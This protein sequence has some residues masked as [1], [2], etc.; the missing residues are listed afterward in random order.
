MATFNES[1]FELCRNGSADE[2]L[3]AIRAGADV[4]ARTPDGYM[5]LGIAAM[6][7][8]DIESVRVL[9]D[10]GGHL[11]IE[12]KGYI[13]MMNIILNS[14]LSENAIMLLIQRG[15][16]A[17]TKAHDGTTI[18]ML[19]AVR[20]TNAVLE[21]L[22]KAGSDVNAT[23]CDGITALMYAARKDD[24]QTVNVLL[25]AGAFVNAKASNGMTSLHY[26]AMN[27][28]S[29]AVVKTLLDAGAYDS[30]TLDGRT[31]LMFAARWNSPEI[32]AAILEAGSDV[33]AVDKDCKT[34]LD[35]ALENEKL[36][37]TGII[38]R[39]SARRA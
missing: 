15:M 19:S 4:N 30:V 5:P 23:R 16:L 3:A 14:K 31:A 24:P 39:I 32:V 22:L 26:A 2:I 6:F 36:K 11:N 10:A 9:L 13:E 18:L 21:A 8:R 28:H 7:N 38:E 17:N 35:Y 34:A 27:S 25:R 1:F 29:L 33:D 20:G 12:G 37:N